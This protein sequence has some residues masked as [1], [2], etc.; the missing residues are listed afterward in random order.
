MEAEQGTKLACVIGHII[1]SAPSAVSSS[2]GSWLLQPSAQGAAAASMACCSP[3]SAL[4]ALDCA[5]GGAGGLPAAAVAVDWQ[6]LDCCTVLSAGCESTAG[7]GSAAAVG[8]LAA[9]AEPLRPLPAPSCCVLVPFAVPF[10]APLATPF[11]A[12]F[13]A[14]DSAAAVASEAGARTPFG[15]RFFLAAGCSAALASAAA[16]ASATAAATASAA[17]ASASARAAALAALPFGRFWD[18]ALWAGCSASCSN[19]KGQRLQAAYLIAEHC[20]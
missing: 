8:P 18:C 17:A 6:G 20:H 4:G 7:C 5:E 19:R 2:P 15:R 12:P 14:E 13:A 16:A 9:E 1:Q 3:L 11:T 10:E